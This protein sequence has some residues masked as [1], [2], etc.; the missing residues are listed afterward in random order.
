VDFGES[1]KIK[2]PVA[3]AAGDCLVLW[4]WLVIAGAINV[5]LP[6]TTMID[7][8]AGEDRF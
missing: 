7:F 5:S 6:C 1:E 8:W 4:I 2:S 3:D